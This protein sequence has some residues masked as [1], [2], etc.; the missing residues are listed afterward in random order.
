MTFD[1]V[2]EVPRLGG[3]VLRL[4]ELRHQRVD[5]RHRR[6]W[7]GGQ[8]R[9]PE[10]TC[11]VCNSFACQQQGGSCICKH[12]SKFDITTILS[13]GRREYVKLVR[14]YNKA[15]PNKSLKVTIKVV[16]ETLIP[17]DGTDKSGA[18]TFMTPSSSGFVAIRD[19]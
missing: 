3:A 7:G 18:L 15:F 2:V 19:R 13:K 16:R 9:Y 10:P 1:L 6:Q 11:S 12:T 4:H 14:K 5:D 8:D 17:P